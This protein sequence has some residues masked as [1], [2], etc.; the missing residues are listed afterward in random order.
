MLTKIKMSYKKIREKFD[1]SI[2]KSLN[3]TVRRYSKEELRELISTEDG[4]KKLANKVFFQLPESTKSA[5]KGNDE[6]REA[7]SNDVSSRLTN[8]L[9]TPKLY[10]KVFGKK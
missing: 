3:Q 7:F 1:P 8:I 6:A 2:L 10:K 9:D 4:Q 5:F